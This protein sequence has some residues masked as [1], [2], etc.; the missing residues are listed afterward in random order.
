M[1]LYFTLFLPKTK[2]SSHIANGL[3]L[4]VANPAELFLFH[5]QLCLYILGLLITKAEVNGW[6]A[7]KTIAPLS[8]IILLYCCH[9]PSFAIILKSS[10][11][12]SKFSPCCS[13]LYIYSSLYSTFFPL[14]IYLSKGII[15]S[16][17]QA[18]VPYGKSQSIISILLSSMF[19]INSK[20]SPLY[21]LFLSNILNI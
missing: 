4:A 8:L 7:V 17:L 3:I 11:D 1:G 16:H 20:Q 10:F 21:T 9:K 18:V 6:L 2:T 12:F 19:F 15:T 13:L 5:I 14:I